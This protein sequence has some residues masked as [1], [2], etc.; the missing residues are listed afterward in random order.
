MQAA[1]AGDRS[2]NLNRFKLGSEMGGSRDEEPIKE[3]AQAA[4]PNMA[5]AE[6][7]RPDQPIMP[8][9]PDP[10]PRAQAAIG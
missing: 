7:L 10:P 2:R 1:L 3:G 8:R 9:C 4:R 5:W 6:F